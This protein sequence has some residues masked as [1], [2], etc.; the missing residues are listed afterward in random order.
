MQQE[1]LELIGHA[2]KVLSL[3]WHHIADNVLASY[4]MDSTIKIW[5]VNEGKAGI[6]YADHNAMPTAM[7][8]SPKGD[9][10]AL[11]LKNKTMTFFDPR[12]KDSVLSNP[13]HQSAR[14]QKIAWINDETVVTVGFDKQQQREYAVWDL[15]N[16]SDGPIATDA[17]GSEGSIP[18]LH[19]DR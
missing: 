11:M 16:L 12:S 14:A 10:L 9:V 15:R 4:S 18:S 19:F 2:K 6:T 3:R 13:A 8:W 17:L 7:R 5:D 1:D